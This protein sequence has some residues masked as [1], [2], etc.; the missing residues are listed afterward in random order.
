P[1]FGLLDLDAEQPHLPAGVSYPAWIKPVESASSE[2]AYRI[3]SADQLAKILP[4]AREDVVRMGRPFE[5]ILD[6]IELPPEIE[7]IG[8]TAYMAEEAASGQQFTVE[9]YVAG[10]AVEVYGLVASISY[11]DSA[12]FLRYQYPSTLGEATVERIVE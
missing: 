4:Q 8:G 5:A 10:G 9:G 11:P 12:S 7:E 1:A 2:G 6:L 3:D